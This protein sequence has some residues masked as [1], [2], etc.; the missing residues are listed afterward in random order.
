[1]LE[2]IKK[3]SET[4]NLIE[5]TLIW[6]NRLEALPLPYAGE[7]RGPFKVKGRA[8]L[9]FGLYAGGGPTHIQLGPHEAALK[10]GTL[11][12]LNAHFG[13]IGTPPADG[14]PLS[15]WWTSFDVA[16]DSPVPD[17]DKAP[18]L[19]TVPVRNVAR[20]VERCRSVCRLHKQ[21]QPFQAIRLKSEVLNLLADLHESVADPSR[22]PAAY[23]PGIEEAV[24]FLFTGYDRA[25]LTRG[26][27]AR[28]A[29]LSEAHFGRQ[30]RREV[31]V[32]PL[33]YVTRLRVARACELLDRTRLNV[34][35]VG[36]AAGFGDPFHFSRTFRKSVGV[37]PRAYRNAGAGRL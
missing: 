26:E 21:Q 35:E 36:R 33:Q 17:L 12:T 7:D 25:G 37:S 29:H 11:V 13:Y 15:L 8:L 23:S 22:S 27:L 19:L 10:P 20:L 28:V 18:M 9:E 16:N 2:S 31:G 5:N 30:F 14:P 3:L 32:T 34:E 24:R 6:A 4:C 1:M